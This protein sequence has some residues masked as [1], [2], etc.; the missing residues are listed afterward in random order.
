[1]STANILS[2][3]LSLLLERRCIFISSDITVLSSVTHACMAMIY[4]FTWQHVFIP[5]LPKSLLDYVCSPVPFI[6]GV[7]A[8]HRGIVDTMPMEE[9]VFIDLDKD[10]VIGGDDSK[11]LPSNSIAKKLDS[12]KKQCKLISRETI[13]MLTIIFIAGRSKSDNNKDIAD[14][15]LE[16]F[17]SHFG[18]YRKCMNEISDRF[19]FSFEKFIKSKGKKEKKFFEA[20]QQS[21][22]FERWSWELESVEKK[23]RNGVNISE[24]GTFERKCSEKN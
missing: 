18:D 19:E 20:F 1:M 23:I 10:K 12:I 24:L 5:V 16:F 7:L 21:Q 8:S 11:Q 4:P 2:L 9:V 13:F 14:T 6:V 17:L 3:F 15:F 22:M